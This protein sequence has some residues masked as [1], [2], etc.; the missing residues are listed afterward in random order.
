MLSHA[1]LI[2]K[3][4]LLPPSVCKVESS[5][6]LCCFFPLLNVWLGWCLDY[7]DPSLLLGPTVWLPSLRFHSPVEL[8]SS[9]VGEPQRE[10]WTPK[11]KD[12]SVL[13]GTVSGEGMRGPVEFSLFS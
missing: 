3:D 12:F 5:L 11:A 7:V 13:H 1:P 9:Q 2:S 10:T 8:S 4:Q 6:F